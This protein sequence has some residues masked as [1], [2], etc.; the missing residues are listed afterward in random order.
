MP[1]T[2][3]IIIERGILNSEVATRIPE[4][5]TLEPLKCCSA[6]T[7]IRKVRNGIRVILGVSGTVDCNLRGTKLSEGGF[8]T[9]AIVDHCHLFTDGATILVSSN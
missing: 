7:D 1:P 5:S 9:L 4:T 3:C 6:P 2:K 8:Q